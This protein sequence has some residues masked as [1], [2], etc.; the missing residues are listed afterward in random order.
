MS[1]PY[2]P[3]FIDDYEAATAHLSMLE[4]GAYNRLLR[5][6]WRSPGCKLPNDE[7]W[8]MRKMR[9]TQEA[10]QAAVKSVL[11]EFFTVGR[12]KIWSKRLL[13]V[14]LQKSV[15]HSSR[16][17]AGKKGAAAKSLKTNKSDFSNAK[18]MLKQPEPEPEPE[19][20]PKEEGGDDSAREN[21]GQ[22]LSA[23]GVD[24]VSGMHGPNGRMIGTQADMAEANRWIDDLGL[25]ITEVVDE[26]SA[27]MR[28]KSDGP[29]S[30]FSYFTEAMRR[31]SAAKSA[32][33]IQ[34][35]EIHQFPAPT[36]DP[37]AFFRD[38]R[39]AS[40]IAQ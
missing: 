34:P 25:S 7:A 30:R 2:L 27:I 11:S 20:E 36:F 10:E 37:V 29:P 35:A 4:D 28:R 12:G 3:L 38:R 39:A 26:I 23:I 9:A 6:C 5:L 13:E 40:E 1:L 16:I 32:P 24:P 33:R 15:A 18:A 31:L 22:I 17:E 14:H 21:R 19:P 8:I